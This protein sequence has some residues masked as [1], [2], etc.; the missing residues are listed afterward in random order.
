M[1]LRL[2]SRGRAREAS[3]R[4]TG[5]L[6]A[7]AVSAGLSIQ[8]GTAVAEESD[9]VSAETYLADLV[10]RVSDTQ[11][12]LSALE[13]E[14]GGLRESVNK[15]RVDFDRSAHAAQ[16]AQDAVTGAR[17]RLGGTHDELTSAQADLDQIARSAYVQGGDA[18]PIPLAAGVNADDA[19]DRASYIRMAAQRQKAEVDRLDLARTQAANEESRLRDARNGA[20]D[21]VSAA[22][23]ARDEA[24]QRFDQV[25]QELSDKTQDHE[26]LLTAVDNAQNQLAAARSA[27]DQLVR[28]NSGATS[29]QK[30]DAAE[31]AV[32]K[33]DTAATEGAADSAAP[34][35]AA[36]P[37]DVSETTPT[38]S[39][40]T[41]ATAPVT[42]TETAEPDVTDLPDSAT[43]GETTPEDTTGSFS[44]DAAGD[45]RRQ[46][47]IDG[48]VG[49]AGAALSAGADAAA[50]GGNPASAARHA[51]QDSAAHAYEALPSANG[52][53]GVGED[54]GT[55]GDTDTADTD[56]IDASEVDDPTAG[57]S[58]SGAAG[59][60]GDSASPDATGTSAA[61]IERVVDRGMSQLGITY[62][63]GGGN[64][65]GPTLGIR[66]GGVADAYG[67][68]NKVGFD[69]SG[70]MMYSFYAVGIQLDHYSGYQYTAG[71]QVPIEQARRGDMLF[72]GAG[73]SSHVALYLGDGKMLEAPQSG[74]V[75]KV[76]DVRW[77]G[78]MPYATRMIE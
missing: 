20:D 43:T 10:S 16:E 28:K 55:E 76:S 4:G 33:V 11:G 7:F 65:Y 8:M 37:A 51:A 71:T 73:G 17:S 5:A 26:K 74:D 44:Q 53:S 30:R 70:L 13:D 67:D 18:S 72:W 57:V 34:A 24:Q 68:Y 6:L 35:D 41:D 42:P 78:I 12:E 1:A 39:P 25:Q 9:G 31:A 48:L 75:V 23:G 21:L 46:A 27:V 64:W 32:A 38:S 60:T 15:N 77:S 19:I 3:V 58:N 52:G 54:A 22:R 29:F 45:A 56:G 14:L 50:A 2:T 62:A 47:A 36:D 40:A 49:A 61:Q 69:C 63:W 59:G 66:D